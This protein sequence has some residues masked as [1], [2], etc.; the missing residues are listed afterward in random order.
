MK[1]NKTLGLTATAALGLLNIP[2]ASRAQSYEPYERSIP[3]AGDVSQIR[4]AR[5]PSAA[6]EAYAVAIK[7][8][9]KDLGVED[10][11]V[12]KMVEFGLPEMAAN[13]AADVAARDPTNGLA[14]AVVAFMNAH[15]DRT[16]DALADIVV[17]ARLNPRDPFVLRTAG[18]I[19][20]WYD[21]QAE[22]S[23]IDED[24]RA[25]TEAMRRDLSGRAEF[26]N[27][28]ARARAAYVGGDV[29]ETPPPPPPPSTTYVNTYVYSDPYVHYWRPS[30]FYDSWWH[31]PWYDGASRFV[32]VGGVERG[33]FHRRDGFRD[34][35]RERNGFGDRSRFRSRQG[36]GDGQNDRDGVRDRGRF[37]DRNGVRPRA[38]VPPTDTPPRVRRQQPRTSAPRTSPREFM[39][40]TQPATPS[41]PRV[42]PRQSTIPQQQ[43]RQSPRRDRRD[44]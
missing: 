12:R 18:Q 19:A 34:G 3:A 26:D 36:F 13:Q 41:Q 1:L 27:A 28:Y 5:D 4:D 39:P 42:Q 38:A 17:A 8:A 11:F 6:V 15:R 37:Q 35:R 2:S 22:Q 32:I 33:R 40:R 10:A 24:L 30:T 23:E 44:R 9:P 16:P 14:R 21:T 31:D 7:L 25:S 29:V 43:P 20:A